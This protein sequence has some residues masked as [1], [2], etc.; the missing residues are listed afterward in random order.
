MVTYDVRQLLFE[1]H[2][3]CLEFQTITLKMGGGLIIY[4]KTTYTII[5][6]SSSFSAKSYFLLTLDSLKS[7]RIR[8]SISRKW[9]LKI[10]LLLRRSIVDTVAW[11]NKKMECNEN[12]LNQTV[13]ILQYFPVIGTVP[14]W[15]SSVS[16]CNPS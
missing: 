5:L 16:T 9:I 12:V 6:A 1:F 2:E 4:F 10:S 11:K 7:T 14:G 3:Y 8:S 13:I 15:Y